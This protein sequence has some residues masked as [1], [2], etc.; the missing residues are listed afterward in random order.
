MT[1][2]FAKFL[3]FQTAFF[4]H[5]FAHKYIAKSSRP[6]GARPKEKARL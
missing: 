3:S 4:L 6:L 5:I 1:S 2:N